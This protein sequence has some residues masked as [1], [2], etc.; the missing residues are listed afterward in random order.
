MLALWTGYT[1]FPAAL[2]QIESPVTSGLNVPLM[3]AI[4]QKGIKSELTMRA[5][6]KPTEMIHSSVH[7]P[8]SNRSGQSRS[9][10]PNT[11]KLEEGR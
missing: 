8:K 9:G 7:F 3:S 6:R 2:F 11:N 1:N 10:Y 4:R 5:N